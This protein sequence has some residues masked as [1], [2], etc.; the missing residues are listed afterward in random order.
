MELTHDHPAARRLLDAVGWGARG[1]AAR[2]QRRLS[3]VNTIRP[4]RRARDQVNL[5]TLLQT[6]AAPQPYSPASADAGPAP[7]CV[8]MNFSNT[9]RACYSDTRS[10]RAALAHLDARA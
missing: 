6:A 2:V 8:L 10:R 9:A 1:G 7:A 4:C 3:Q 5:L